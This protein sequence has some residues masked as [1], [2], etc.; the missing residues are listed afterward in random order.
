MAEGT[1]IPMEELRARGFDAEGRQEQVDAEESERGLMSAA[2]SVREATKA[3]N[4]VATEDGLKNFGG[5]DNELFNRLAQF[6]ALMAKPADK[7]TPI[8]MGEARNIARWAIDRTAERMSSNSPYSEVV[9]A[10]EGFLEQIDD[11]DGEAPAA[12]A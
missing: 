8:V 6:D 3:L 11:G 5:F 2:Q 10:L 12:A 9:A 7:R 1:P 4:K